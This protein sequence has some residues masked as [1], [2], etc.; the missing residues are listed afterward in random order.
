MQEEWHNHAGPLQRVV[1]KMRDTLST[2]RTIVDNGSMDASAIVAAIA[3][4]ITLAALYFTRRQVKT[5]E[6]QTAIQRGG[7]YKDAAQP[8]VWADIRPHAQHASFM[9][10]ILKNEGP[11]VAT[12]VSLKINPGLPS[13]WARN[14]D[15]EKFA[16]MR[17]F[18]SLPPGR[19]MQW[20][21]GLPQDLLPSPDTPGN[22]DGRFKI[23]ISFRGPNGTKTT[24]S[25]SINL[26][27]YRWVAKTTP[28]TPPMT[29]AKSVDDAT[30]T[31]S[32]AINN[33]AIQLSE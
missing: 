26:S 29:I 3:A 19:M 17:C 2:P 31:L 32:K 23:S 24:L 9:M 6:E 15:H 27:E 25:Y 18:D 14:E 5:A 16:S 1:G 11:T 8:Y 28:G 21:L 33:V 10:L 20:N 12:D 7:M 4:A 13:E 22:G 30:K